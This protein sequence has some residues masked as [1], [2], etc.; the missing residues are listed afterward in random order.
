[1]KSQEEKLKVLNNQRKQAPTEKVIPSYQLDEWQRND[2]ARRSETEGGIESEDGGCCNEERIQLIL[3]ERRDMPWL[4]VGFAAAF[5]V[6]F[7]AII[8]LQL[9]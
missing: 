4:I 3:P 7:A 8:L 1:M 6:V 5:T 2:Q 9:E